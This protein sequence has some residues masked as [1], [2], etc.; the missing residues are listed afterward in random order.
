MRNNQKER[1]SYENQISRHLK[2]AGFS[3][4][5]L[6]LPDQITYNNEQDL[7]YNLHYT[8]NKFIH[9]NDQT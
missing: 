9:T 4:V 5:S 2:E 8:F 1:S 6:N 3:P 7:V